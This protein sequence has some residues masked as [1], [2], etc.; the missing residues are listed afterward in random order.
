MERANIFGANKTENSIPSL[1]GKK[2]LI[3]E[4]DFY[5]REM[6]T[7][8]L[9]KTKANLFTATDGEETLKIFFSNKIDVVLLDI[10]LPV[11]DGYDVIKR[12]RAENKEI[13]VIAQTGFLTLSDIKKIKEA[14]FTGYISKP[15]SERILFDTIMKYLG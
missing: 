1:E 8:L 12:L 5:S 2:I 4:D 9:N 10:R 3:A 15:V 6:L 7:Y 14:G 11:L 13:V